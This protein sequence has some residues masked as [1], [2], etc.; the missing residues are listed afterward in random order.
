MGGHAGGQIASTIATHEMG[1]HVVEFLHQA[2]NSA[3]AE[4]SPVDIYTILKGALFNANSQVVRITENY[5]SL[6][7]MGSTLTALLAYKD[8]AYFAHVGDS[9][10]YLIRD[11]KIIQV[12]EDHSYV[13]ELVNF[14]EISPEEAHTHIRRNLILRSVSRNS[15]MLDVADV[16]T[17]C[18]REGD[19]FLICSDGL[20][21]HV[22]DQ[23]ILETILTQAPAAVP[24]ALIDQA[25][26]SE[27]RSPSGVGTDNTTVVLVE[28][29]KHRSRR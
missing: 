22:R 29:G 20:I 15:A 3:R 2:E 9:R 23:D 5:P 6:E 17:I 28:V 24:Q 14:G 13:Q 27:N 21:E 18:M 10:A 4:G 1:R 25:N 19:R 11:E 7:S 12:T 16:A 26:S 8:K